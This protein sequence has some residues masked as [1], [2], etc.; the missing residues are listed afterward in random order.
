MVSNWH[1]KSLALALCIGTVG[2]MEDNQPT[3]I[4]ATSAGKNSLVLR[5]KTR[6]ENMDDK[7]D[8]IAVAIPGFG[9]A[10]IGGDGSTHVYLKNPKLERVAEMLQTVLPGTAGARVETAVR[11]TL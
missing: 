10:F 11:R 1:V 8:S 3:S 9:G 6:A 5:S 7:F 2:C 4:Q